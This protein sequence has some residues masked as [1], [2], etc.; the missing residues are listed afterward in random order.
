MTEPFAAALALNDD[1]R[2]AYEYV[3]QAPAAKGYGV[4]RFYRLKR[5]PPKDPGPSQ[6]AKQ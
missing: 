1:G 5:T 2:F 4:M 3:G 6:T